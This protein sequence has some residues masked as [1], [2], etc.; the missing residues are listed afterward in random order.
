MN[1]IRPVCPH[2]SGVIEHTPAGTVDPESV[3][4][5]RCGWYQERGTA[6]LSVG[7]TTEPAKLSRNTI[8]LCPG[9]RRGGLTIVSG[10]KCG[11]CTH[12]L[13]KGIDLLAPS[14][15]V[16]PGRGKNRVA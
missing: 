13:K 5:L 4:C 8:G 7:D 6:E 12:R 10:G 15:S 2:C 9:C 11:R 14:F 3:R 1:I 16:R